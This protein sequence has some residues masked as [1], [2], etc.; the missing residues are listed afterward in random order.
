MLRRTR[1]TQSPTSPVQTQ[2]DSAAFDT[3]D[4]QVATTDNGLTTRDD[5]AGRQRTH[6]V[7]DG[8]TGVATTLDS[9]GGAVALSE[10]LGGSGL[11]CTPAIQRDEPWWRLVALK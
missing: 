5:A 11:Y 8:A 9:E 6:T 10:S 4:Y 3:A 2:T 7:V 1:Q